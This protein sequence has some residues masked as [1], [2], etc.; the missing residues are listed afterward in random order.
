MVWLQCV[1]CSIKLCKVCI[2]R[3]QNSLT[4]CTK[5]NCARDVLQRVVLWFS[6]SLRFLCFLN[7]W[8]LKS[9]VSLQLKGHASFQEMRGEVQSLAPGLSLPLAFKKMVC[10]F[11]HWPEL[12][13]F[14]GHHCVNSKQ[15]DAQLWEFWSY[16]GASVVEAPST[17]HGT[18]S[19]RSE[20]L[21]P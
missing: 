14:P 4:C 8:A 5:G 11:P 6:T 12:Q 16:N 20:G 19:L 9:G 15:P 3:Q 7:V 21:T 10:G 13:C 17:G 1:G 2:P 18:S